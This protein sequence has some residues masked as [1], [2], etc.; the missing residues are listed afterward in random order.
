MKSILNILRIWTREIGYI[1]KDKGIVTFILFVPLMY[2]LLYSYVYTGEVVREVPVAVVNEDDNSFTR[3]IINRLD[4]SPDVRVIARCGD[5]REAEEF[6][7]RQEAYGVV[8]IPAG[9]TDE[10][11]A[12]HQVPLGV[13]CDM[14]SMLYYKA[15]LLTA[16]NVSLDVN[17]DIRVNHYL[18]GSTDRQD[19]ING[20]PIEYEY[21]PLY[22][23][24][25]GFAAFLIPPVLMLIIQ[26]TL[27][28]GI[29]MSIGNSRERNNGM[30]I[31]YHPWYKNPVHVVIGKA[32]PYFMLYIVLAVYMFVCVTGAFKLP[33]LGDYRTFVAFAVPYILACI[34][35]AMVLSSFIYRREDCIL[36]FVFLSVPMLFLSGVSWPAVSMP[37]FWKY[38]SYLFPSTFGMNGYVRITSMGASLHDIRADY[39]ALWIQTG[40]YFILACFFY[41]RQIKLVFRHRVPEKESHGGAERHYRG[42]DSKH[43]HGTAR[44]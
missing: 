44:M 40:I 4:A 36:L 1:F 8:R 14:S 28:L 17:K 30:V 18:S 24:Q 37:G 34:F 41:R 22:N 32:L 31:G 27:L 11:T 43:E 21:K 19:E 13:Y 5:M 38:F 33:R 3:D 15:I 6:V 39:M 25:S 42:G 7:K 9:F 12:G 10:L 29:G 23:P 26:Q 2:P 16:T 35:L 20:T